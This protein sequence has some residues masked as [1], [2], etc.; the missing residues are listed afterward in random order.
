[1]Y[2]VR[3]TFSTDFGKYWLPFGIP[4][5]TF[6]HH[7]SIAFRAWILHRFV[8]DFGVDFGHIIDGFA[9][10]VRE[11]EIHQTNIENETK[12]RPNI[13]VKSMQ[14]PCSKK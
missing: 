9:R 5:G 8:I 14:N 6:F 12:I 3:H 10:W 7:F 13:D 4:F 2:Y 1:L 11:R